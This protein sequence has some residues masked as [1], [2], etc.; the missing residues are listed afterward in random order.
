M[1]GGTFWKQ[2]VIPSGKGF[3]AMIMFSAFC[4]S[5]KSCFAFEHNSFSDSAQSSKIYRNEEWSSFHLSAMIPISWKLIFPWVLCCNL[6]VSSDSERLIVFLRALF[7]HCEVSF[8]TAINQALTFQLKVNTVR[9][10]WAPRQRQWFRSVLF[11]WS[12]INKWELV[13]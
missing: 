4:R 7:I 5:S 12:G 9:T 10:D 13:W 6:S 11:Q 1:P 3:S 2:W 8:V